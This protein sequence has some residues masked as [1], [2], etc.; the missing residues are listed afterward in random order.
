MTQPL[1]LLTWNTGRLY[2]PWLERRRPSWTPKGS[3]PH[4]AAWLLRWRPHVVFLQEIPPDGTAKQ[5]QALL[6]GAPWRAFI[7]DMPSSDR[8]ILTL[9]TLPQTTWQPI[10]TGTGR[11]AAALT[12]HSNLHL[13]GCH[14]CA[15]NPARRLRYVQA[16][17][18][19]ANTQPPDHTTALLGDFNIDPLLSPHPD[20]RAAIKHLRAERFTH[21][22][23]IHQRHTFLNCLQLDHLHHRIGPG[24]PR[25][26]FTTQVLPG[27]GGHG[28]DHAPLWTTIA[29]AAD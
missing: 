4:I 17:T 22:P 6:G 26:T 13:V 14:A 10:A 28:R 15:H 8:Q 11:H 16:L 12:V 2:L 21:Q 3:L 27:T 25:R 29:P 19:W 24:A 1:R 18:H 7:T 9:T 5:L 23:P 20:D